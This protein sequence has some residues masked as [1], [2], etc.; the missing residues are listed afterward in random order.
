VFVTHGVTHYCVSNMPGAYPRTSTSALTAATL[1]YVLELA[2]GGTRALASP[3]FAG[4]LSTFAGFLTHA[5]AAESLG[6]LAR[7]RAPAELLR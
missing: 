6:M 2:A 4:G 7:Y 3:T 5:A 1:P